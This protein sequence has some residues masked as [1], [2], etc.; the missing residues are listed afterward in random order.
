MQ[1]DVSH[2]GLGKSALYISTEAALSTSRLA[3]ILESMRVSCPEAFEDP[4]T[5][6]NLSR[7]HSVQCPDLESQNHILTYQLPIA[8]RRFDVG[9]VIIDSIAAN[10][11]TGDTTLQNPDPAVGDIQLSISDPKRRAAILGQRSVDLFRI[12]RHLQRVAIE[13][14]VAIVVANQVSDWIVND[15]GPASSTSVVQNPAAPKYH[16][17]AVG[18]LSAPESI[19]PVVAPPVDLRASFLDSVD[20]I[21][22]ASSSPMTDSQMQRLA[23]PTPV[24]FRAAVARPT[25]ALARA[26]TPKLEA[27]QT[28]GARLR[29]AEQN[30]A[31][32]NLSNQTEPPKRKL[33]SEQHPHPDHPPN[34]LPLTSLSASPSR[35]M[36]LDHQMRWF[37]GWGEP[38]GFTSSIHYFGSLKT[39]ALGLTWTNLV[40]ARF[41]IKKGEFVDGKGKVVVRRRVECVF[42]AWTGGG[43]ER[44]V[45][46]EIWEG[47]VRAVQSRR[48]EREEGS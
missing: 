43:R 37:S 44:G 39:P 9:V 18:K 3:Q 47:G 42:A 20:N 46:C 22:L 19:R 2:G 6:P 31:S 16:M 11:R 36:S 45:E 48:G 7:V 8:I 21:S 40:S 13:Q 34:Q 1:L 25:R 26:V 23:T 10:F 32:S 29:I 17:G 33:A 14:H 27:G 38:S 35:I 41:V 12:G 24:D 4:T 15:N 28:A 30:A 5:A